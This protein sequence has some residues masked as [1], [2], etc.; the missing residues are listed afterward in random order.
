MRIRNKRNMKL[1][2]MLLCFLVIGVASADIMSRYLTWNLQVDDADYVLS[3]ETPEPTSMN[4]LD[5]LS[6]TLRLEGPDH[7]DFYIL[8]KVVNMPIDG[9]YHDI[10]LTQEGKT[11]QTPDAN[12]E[13]IFVSG[14]VGGMKLFPFEMTIGVPGAWQFTFV[15][16]TA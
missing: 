11:P 1:A 7:N 16:Q 14:L 3:W 13:I 6:F 15:M 2:A 10:E 12:G 4:V 5:S 9:A 8:F